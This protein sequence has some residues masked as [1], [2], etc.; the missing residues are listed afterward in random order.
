M[1]IDA[2]E[3]VVVVVA[4]LLLIVTLIVMATAMGKKTPNSV[5]AASC[6]D[7][8][9][10]SYYRPCSDMPGGCCPDGVTPS[11]AA[12]DNCANIAPAPNGMCDDGY[13]PKD[14]TG[15]GCPAPAPMCYNTHNLGKK[16]APS[17]LPQGECLKND[18][19]TADYMGSLGMCRKQRFAERC[20]VSWEG[21]SNQP[22]PKG[23][24]AR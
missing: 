2:F 11:T 21:I 17:T 24:P 13:T 4:V 8:W 7:F 23:C 9:F 3:K 1:E 18:F 22:M 20:Q 14:A 5:V 19:T 15:G 10:S 16:I 12:N 6:P